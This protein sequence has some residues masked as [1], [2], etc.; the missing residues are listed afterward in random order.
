M[1]VHVVMH[2]HDDVGWLK[3]KD[4]YYSGVNT[5]HRNNANVKKILDSVTYELAK[6]ENRKFSYVEMSYFSMWWDE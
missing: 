6:D 1:N 3:T 5:E 4:H 2:T